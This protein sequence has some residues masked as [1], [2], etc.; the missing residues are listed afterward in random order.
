[1]PKIIKKNLI[2]DAIAN[3]FADSGASDDYAQ[4][5]VVGVASAIM[6]CGY[7]FSKAMELIRAGMSENPNPN[8]FPAAWHENL[9]IIEAELREDNDR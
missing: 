7:S 6:A 9:G 4:G 2:R 3:T 5:V 1:M 8:R